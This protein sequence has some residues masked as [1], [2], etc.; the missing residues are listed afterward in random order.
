VY[1]YN[2]ASVEEVTLENAEIIRLFLNGND[3]MGWEFVS[4][5]GNFFVF[6]RLTLHQA[7]VAKAASNEG[8]EIGNTAYANR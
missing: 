1:E 2:V 5:C 3:A 6:R 8:V 7:D 4:M